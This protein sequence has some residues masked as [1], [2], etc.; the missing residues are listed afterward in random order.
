MSKL[1]RLNF[2]RKIAE[3]FEKGAKNYQLKKIT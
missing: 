3:G 2:C 1:G